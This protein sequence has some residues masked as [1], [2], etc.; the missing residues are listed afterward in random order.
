MVGT[1]ERHD[2]VYKR[3]DVGCRDAVGRGFERTGASMVCHIEE[4][5]LIPVERSKCVSG[6]ALSAGPT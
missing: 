2:V 4:H 5:P 1:Y 3:E 6:S